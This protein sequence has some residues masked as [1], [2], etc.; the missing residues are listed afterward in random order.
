MLRLITLLCIV[1]LSLPLHAFQ[2]GIALGLYD[3]DPQRSYLQ[4]LKEIKKI[5]ADHI[6]LIVSWYQKD[7]H[8][9]R[10]YPRWQRQGDFHTLSDKKLIEVIEQAHQLGLNVFLFPILRIEER[11]DKDW[12]GSLV[13]QNHHQWLKSYEQFTLHYAHLAATHHVS[14]FSV[15][16]ELC[17]MEKE[18]V[19]WNQLITTIRNFYSGQLIY[20]ANWDHYKSIGFWDHLDFLGLNGY[21]ELTTSPHP[22]LKELVKKWW[23]IENE[24]TAWQE[25]HHKNIIF[26]EIGYPSL[27]GGCHKP[28]DY[29]QQTAVDLEEQ[30]TCYEA[31][32]LS[33][34]HNPALAGVYFWNWYGQGG[35]NDRSYTPRG[36]PAEKV[37]TKW[38]QKKS[39]AS[40]SYSEPV[41][42]SPALTP[43]TS[44]KISPPERPL[45]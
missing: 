24:I 27:S 42:S 37:L 7:I 30:A 36:K 20:S 22:T 33:W 16:S 29:T 12:R 8:A 10:I 15:G 26:T 5:G 32:F 2:N 17:S 19:Y 14:L 41:L 6:S 23:D 43:S 40:Y 4:D 13:P 25:Q 44:K 18:T 31:F 21:Y 45:F 28:W 39:S 11:K 34:N 38:F 35:V 9:T 1:L 3:K